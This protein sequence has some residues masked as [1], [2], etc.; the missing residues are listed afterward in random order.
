MGLN[1]K[2]M[3]HG[4]PQGQRK[5]GTEGDDNRYLS[6][7]YGPKWDVP[8]I[9]KVEL[10][11][12][13]Q[14]T[15]CYYTFLKGQNVC[16]V[17]GRPGSYIA[18]TLKVNAFYADANNIYNLLKAAYE[19]M[20]VGTCVSD[21]GQLVKYLVA[22][23][24]DVATQ[25]DQ[26]E[27]HIISYIG[28]F[29]VASDVVSFSQLKLDKNET[30][31]NINLAECTP[32]VALESVQ[33][34]ESFF[35]SP[36]F[37]S[38]SASAMVAR[39][40]EAMLMETKRVKEDSQY[41][42]QKANEQLAATKEDSQRRI[43]LLQEQ[44]EQE[45]NSLKMQ[46][47]QEMIALKKSYSQFEVDRERLEKQIKDYGVKLQAARND[48]EAS[49]KSIKKT[50]KENE[51]LNEQ[52]LSLQQKLQKQ[53]TERMYP[54]HSKPRIKVNLNRKILLAILSFILFL[55]LL[56]SVF[57]L[58]SGRCRKEDKS[59]T[60]KSSVETQAEPKNNKHNQQTNPTNSQAPG[61]GNTEVEYKIDIKELTK[62]HKYAFKDE[63]L[64]V[65][66]EPQPIEGGK[67]KCDGLIVN[68]LKITA[69]KVGTFTVV[70]LVDGTEITSR[71]IEVKER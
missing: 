21:N 57:W 43:N 28:A 20:C 26:I 14:Q 50:L 17:N 9:M 54:V 42:I 12:L 34:F 53:G 11:T 41:A 4:V 38:T 32:I 61:S 71:T 69:S 36:Y 49:K 51:R 39:Y 56:G 46:H 58:I 25:L 16:D 33:R 15:Y 48:V 10:I 8:E 47:E 27:K 18:L 68:D 62:S 13:G 65:S 55:L 24:N 52:V 29:S 66:I 2:L 31:K 67:I 30:V 60:L 19:K 7:F 70:Y 3:V 64:T 5:W 40:K 59:K 23:F 37:L 1:I 63:T 45:R 6:S 35:V 22:D 44:S